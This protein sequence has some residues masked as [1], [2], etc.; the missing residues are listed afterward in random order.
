MQESSD[1]SVWYYLDKGGTQG[2]VS[3]AFLKD[4]VTA[5]NLPASS[6]VA[7]RGWATWR[8]VSE[9]FPGL[10]TPLAA[11]LPPLPPSAPAGGNVLDPWRERIRKL[12]GTE[13]L[14]GFS[15]REMFSEVF[16]KRTSDQMDDYFVVGTY[17]T[18]PPILEAECGWP[19][20]WLFFRALM[21]VGIVYIAFSFA[22]TQFRNMNL[23]PGLIMMGSL[24]VPLATV[25]L[26]FELNAPRNV[27]LHQTLMLICSGGIASLIVS[28]IGFDIAGLEWLGDMEAGIVEEIGKLAAVVV[29]ARNSRHKYIL[30]GILF[31]AAVGAGFAAFESAGYAFRAVLRGATLDQMAALIR[32]RAVLS[33]FGHVAWTALAA[34]ALWR[35]KKDQKFSPAMLLKPQFLKTFSIPVGLHMLWD[36]PLPSPWYSL[37]VGIGVVGWYVI[38]GL[39][40]Q[41]LKQVRREQTGKA[42]MIRSVGAA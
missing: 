27:S 2:P 29:L 10:P 39:V 6:L 4:H 3:G 7:Q 32:L 18:T 14:E 1:D 34:G 36:S 23:V 37:Q 5:G 35:V 22:F 13:A 17:R 25:I 28:L 38:F 21:F 33:P 30:N 26:F 12:V 20:P 19:K 9:V 31:G 42:T 15:L 16:Q 8:A 40:Q 11:D 41:G 24:A